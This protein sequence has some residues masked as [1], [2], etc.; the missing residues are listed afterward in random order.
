MPIFGVARRYAKDVDIFLRKLHKNAIQAYEIGFVYG[1]P[2]RFPEE[3]TKLAEKLKIKLS[4]HIPFFISWSNEKRIFKSIEHLTRGIRFAAQ[5]KTVAVFHLGYY[6]KVTFQELRN[7][8]IEGIE[9]AIKLAKEQCNLNHPVLGIET[10]G[11]RSEIGSIDEVL[12]IVS[13]LSTNLVIP[14]VDWAHIFA[15]SNGKFPQSTDDFRLI[16]TKLENE[17]GLKNFYFHGSGIEYKNGNEKRHL[18]AKT[19]KPPLPYLFSVLNEL[20]Y[21][22]TF[23]VESP[24]PIN[25]VIWL[26]EVSLNPELWSKKVRNLF[27][28]I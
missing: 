12:S 1:I 8:I 11:K 24:D 28:F 21:D 16:V 3:T 26:K 2:E 27:D 18:S 10:T 22:Y 14:V 9:N 23:I 5:L 7:K 25:D 17:I 6:G 13:D 4:G 19:C 15:R 20:G